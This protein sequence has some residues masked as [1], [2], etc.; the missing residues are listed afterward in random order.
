MTAPLPLRYGR[1]R[2]LV[3]T[4]R[5]RWGGFGDV[6]IGTALVFQ[7]SAAAIVFGVPFIILGIAV[8][9]V[10]RFGTIHYTTLSPAKK[11]VAAIGATIGFVSIAVV[12]LAWIFTNWVIKVV[13]N[14]R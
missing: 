1:G 5:L 9:V 12:V 8:W 14:N 7:G 13:A 6:L 11:A 2:S 4:T 10:T 3:D